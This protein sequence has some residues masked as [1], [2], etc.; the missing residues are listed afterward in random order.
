MSIYLDSKIWGPATWYVM[1]QIAFRLPQT[2]GSLPAKTKA[3]LISFY[4]NLK[5]LLP[6]PSCQKHYAWTLYKTPPSSHF[7]N[8][9]SVS[10]W[11]VNSHNLTNKGLDKKIIPFAVAANM[12]TKPGS[13]YYNINHNLISTFILHIIINWN[14]LI[15]Y[16]KAVATS[17]CYLHPCLKCREIFIEYL[18][19]NSLKDVKTNKDMVLWGKNLNKLSKKCV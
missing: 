11:T 2:T 12:Y 1:H 18:T 14:K 5:P 6:C 9:I 16:R 19:T 4:T 15:N 8:S 13:I 3:Y 17:I 10:K 7:T